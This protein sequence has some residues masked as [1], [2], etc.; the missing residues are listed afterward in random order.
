MENE[1]R[2][3]LDAGRDHLANEEKDESKSEMDLSDDD[4]PISALP[5]IS[6]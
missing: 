1:T 4:F 3:D 5:M 2:D 6:A